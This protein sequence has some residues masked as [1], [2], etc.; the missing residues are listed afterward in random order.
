MSE[1]Q[2]IADYPEWL[3][4]KFIIIGGRGFSCQ[5][6]YDRERGEW[7]ELNND[8]TDHWGGPVEN[9]THWMPLPSP[10]KQVRE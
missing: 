9:V 1:W 8:W 5:A 6:R 2:D 4:G 10:P 3:D 7:W